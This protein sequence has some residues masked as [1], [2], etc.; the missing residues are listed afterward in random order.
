MDS[1]HHAR[2]THQNTI[3]TGTLKSKVGL[4]AWTMD[5]VAGGRYVELGTGVKQN[6]QTYPPVILKRVIYKWLIIN[7]LNMVNFHSYLTSCQMNPDGRSVFTPWN[8]PWYHHYI[9][10]NHLFE[11]VNQWAK[12]GALSTSTRFFVTG[13]FLADS[14]RLETLTTHHGSSVPSW[15]DHLSP[16]FL[17]CHSGLDYNST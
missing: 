4:F 2:A 10:L 13:V 9:P 1:S 5:F 16:R 6:Q 8:I 15:E 11:K 12:S 14:S 17:E 3:Q 7:L